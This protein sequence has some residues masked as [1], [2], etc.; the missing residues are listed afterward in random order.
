MCH[1]LPPSKILNSGIYVTYK[2]PT[3]N[4]FLTDTFHAKSS[5]RGFEYSTKGFIF[6]RNPL[7]IFC[8]LVCKTFCQ[9]TQKL[10]K[11]SVLQQFLWHHHTHPHFGFKRHYLLARSCWV[12]LV[13]LSPMI[14]ILQ[15][16]SKHRKSC[17]RAS[18]AYGS[19]HFCLLN[20]YV[21]LMDIFCSA[22]IHLLTPAFSQKVSGSILR[23]PETLLTFCTSEVKIGEER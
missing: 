20:K 18:I 19:R 22:K 6:A 9:K 17:K 21:C 15:S 10:K 4:L 2:Y 14:N 1:N 8:H 16:P 11:Q 5:T 7:Q 23:L 3:F 13:T 12:Y